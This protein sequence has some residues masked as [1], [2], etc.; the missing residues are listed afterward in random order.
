[1]AESV[2]EDQAQPTTNRFSWQLTI[3]AGGRVCRWLIFGVVL[4]AFPI[5]ISIVF[6]PKGTPITSLLSNGDFAVLASALAG[7][8]VGELLGP[9]EPPKWLRNVLISACFLLFAASSLVL[10]SIAGDAARISMQQKV[11]DSWALFIIAV[12]IGIASMGSTVQRTRY[13]GKSTGQSPATPQGTADEDG[14]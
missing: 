5:L 9:D 11:Y 12:V 6:L 7:A 4:A 13:A 8:A 1:M 3:R 10:A 2:A 14:E